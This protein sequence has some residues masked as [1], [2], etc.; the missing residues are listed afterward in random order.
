MSLAESL[1]NRTVDNLKEHAKALDPLIARISPK[2]KQAQAIADFIEHKKREFVSCLDDAGRLFLAELA[3]EK[4]IP[5]RAVFQARY[6]RKLPHTGIS[7]NCK[8]PSSPVWLLVESDRY[9]GTRIAFEDIEKFREFVPKP[10]AAQIPMMENLPDMAENGFP[11][12]VF[13]GENT[14]QLEA[15]R[16]LAAISQG[17]IKVTSQKRPTEAAMRQIQSLLLQPDLDLEYPK[18]VKSNDYYSRS[19]PGPVRA[20]AWPVVVQQMEWATV[21]AGT[22]KLTAAGRAWLADPTVEGFREAVGNLI[23]DDTFH[24]LNRINH[25]SG[26]NGKAKRFINS[27]DQ[28]RE[29]L[30][31]VLMNC[32]LGEWVPFKS[33]FRCLLADGGVPDVMEDGPSL[34]YLSH[35]QYGT[36]Y[37][38]NEL[39]PCIT[40]GMIME[41]LATIGV[42]DIAYTAPHGLWPELEDNWGVD[43]FC[44]LGRYDGL[45]ALRLNHWG[46]YLLEVSSSYDS[47]TAAFETQTRMK[48]LPNLELVLP[49]SAGGLLGDLLPMVSVSVS[50]H[51]WKLD[52][53]AVL[54]SVSQG[55]RLEELR[56][57]LEENADGPLPETVQD[58]WLQIQ[59]KASACEAVEPAWI[60]T[61]R[62][63]T[64]AITLANSRG[65]QRLCKHAGGRNLVIAKKN[66]NA[67]VR[68]ANRIGYHLPSPS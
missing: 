68:E 10:P 2:S 39:Q 34:L 36:I 67:F 51:V 13:A 20:H 18:E 27:P 58:W 54:R 24:E 59:S 31:T 4:R 17:K 38:S 12:K 7:W 25:I 6:G 46:A 42:V 33:F 1:S 9:I 19:S 56:R 32:P 47:P 48:V 8:E 53:E 16:V 35:A 37:D 23:S 3:W 52:T 11:I 5:N 43:C 50:D 22:L 57:I 41:T 65:F 61:W 62:S 45:L 14:V 55:T 66:W 21:R 64:E 30:A 60:V 28:F 49:D 63:E 15:R 26:Q 40:R 44:Y 29:T